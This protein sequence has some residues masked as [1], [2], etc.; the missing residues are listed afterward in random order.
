MVAAKK[1]GGGTK[2]VYM[3][4]DEGGREVVLALVEKYFDHL[5]QHHPLRYCCMM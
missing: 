5:H 4:M 2:K 3:E 1:R